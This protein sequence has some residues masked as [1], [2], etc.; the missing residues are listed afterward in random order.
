LKKK[1]KKIKKDRE[2]KMSFMN[3]KFIPNI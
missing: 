1:L 2:K 3:K